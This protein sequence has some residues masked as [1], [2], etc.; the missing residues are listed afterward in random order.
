MHDPTA[1]RKL[2]ENGDEDLSGLGLDCGLQVV[3]VLPFGLRGRGPVD[4][5]PSVEAVGKQ[6]FVLAPVVLKQIR[7]SYS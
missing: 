4:R 7:F 2:V 6:L 1:V 3:E 5:G